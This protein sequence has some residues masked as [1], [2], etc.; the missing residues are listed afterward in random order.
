MFQTRMMSSLIRYVAALFPISPANGMGS[1][2]AVEI[3][4]NRNCFIARFMDVSNLS[5]GLS[6]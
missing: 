4:P 2:E 5:E 3:V 1:G 6:L